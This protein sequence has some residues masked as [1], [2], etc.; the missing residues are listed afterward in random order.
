MPNKEKLN[1]EHS[2][3]SI[4]NFICYPLTGKV[5]KKEDESSSK[6]PALTNERALSK[7]V[8]TPSNRAKQNVQTG[9]IADS[10]FFLSQQPTQGKIL[11]EQKPAK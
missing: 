5:A 4:K 9:A 6:K 8:Q 2:L 1:S 3:T 7:E 11:S 10:C